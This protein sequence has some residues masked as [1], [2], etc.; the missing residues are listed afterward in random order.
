[1]SEGKA[2]E[3]QDYEEIKSFIQSE[4]VDR[5]QTLKLQFYI[6]ECTIYI[7]SVSRFLSLPPFSFIVY[8]FLSPMSPP[9]LLNMYPCRPDT[10]SP[11][12]EYL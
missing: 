8:N 10:Y 1:M 12:N 2:M 7:V 6:G 4:I 5:R 9:L 11:H 3:F